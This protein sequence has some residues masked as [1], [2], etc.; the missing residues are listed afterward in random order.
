MIKSTKTSLKFSNKGKLCKLKLFIDEYRRVVSLFV[1][2]LWE[3]ED[4]KPLL[5]KELT[6]QVTTWLSARAVQCAGKQAS[7]IVRGCRKKQVQRKYQIGKFEKLGRLKQARK[8][9]QIYNNVKVSKPNIQLVQPE[10][11]ARFVKVNLKGSTSF[12]GWLSLASL[13]DKAKLTLPFKKTKHFNKLQ[14]QGTLKVGVRLSLDEVTF[15][16]EL[17]A[18]T[19]RTIG[20]TIGIDI[21]QITTLTTSDGQTVDKDKH[22]HSYQSIC[23]KLSRKKRGSRNFEQ[24]DKHRSNFLRWAVNRLN[25]TGVKTVNIEDIKHL[26]RGK[27][28]S[29]SLTHWNY[30]ELVGRLEEKLSDA[31]VQIVKVSPT[32]TSQR[33]SRC[34]WT[35]K[36]NRKGK[37]FKCEKCSFGCDSDLNGSFNISLNLPSIS[38]AERLQRKNLTGF[39]LNVVSE[40][41]IVPHVEKAKNT[42]QHSL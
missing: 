40:V 20:S 36:R 17:P 12:D 7:G 23:D 34:G 16:F 2:V 27:R 39:F 35:R 41:P 37:R 1:D 8:L 22:G 26:R 9:Q 6:S 10:L 15:M 21:G 42:F 33:C 31:G 28:S 25:L 11:D 30:A 19:S 32:Y 13:G 24:A 29:G 3:L 4:V 38:K 5:G 18:P 14:A